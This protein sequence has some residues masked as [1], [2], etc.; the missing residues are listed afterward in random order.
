[1]LRRE[2]VEGQHLVPVLGQTRSRSGILAPVLIDEQIE[3]LV[4]VLLGL[5]HP[6]LVQGILRFWLRFFRQ[7]G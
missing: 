2:T 7:L 6:N 5:G 3:S 4:R 1:M